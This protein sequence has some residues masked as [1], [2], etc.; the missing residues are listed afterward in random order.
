MTD[1]SPFPRALAALTGLAMGDAL[2]MPAQTLPRETIRARY[3]RIE[4]FVAPF[5][6]HPVSHG[7]GPAQ[8]TDDTEQALL[9]ARRLIAEP[10]GFDDRGWAQDLLDW[11][12]DIRAKG[13]SDLLGPSSRRAIDALLAGA[14]PEE[15]GRTGTTNGAAMR[16]APVGIMTPPVPAEIC[17][18]TARTCRVT[19]NTGEAIAAAA[20]VAMTVSCGIAGMDFEMAIGRALEAARLGQSM[21]GAT[22]EPDMAGRIEAALKVAET[23]DIEALIAATGTSVASRESVACAFGLLRLAGDDL[24]QALVAAANIGDDTDT[25]GAITGAMGGAT[26]GRLPGAA[27]DRIRAA[28]D[29]PLEDIAEGL[30]ALRAQAEVQ[31]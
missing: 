8:V 21:G 20:A 31:A 18:A 25:I 13:L 12:A 24:W 14:A 10:G 9:L 11:E 7:L 1:T 3:G 4:D 6:G 22:G 19:H 5:D 26:G 15:T 16:I 2:G 27:T 28:N 23:G 17:A 30:L 29:L